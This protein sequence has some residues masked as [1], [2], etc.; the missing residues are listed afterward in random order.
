MTR[1]AGGL[2]AGCITPSG[3]LII[4][5]HAFPGVLCEQ[6]SLGESW[7]RTL[8]PKQDLDMLSLTVWL[9]SRR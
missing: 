3:L 1:S 6:Y 7:W 2:L 4:T 8:H 9:G 5:S